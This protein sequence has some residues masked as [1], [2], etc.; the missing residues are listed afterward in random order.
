MKEIQ[1]KI[2]YL[3]YIHKKAL[4]ISLKNHL[5]IF[6]IME[7]NQSLICNHLFNRIAH[8]KHKSTCHNLS[9]NNIFI[10]TILYIFINILF[11][12]YVVYCYINEYIYYYKVIC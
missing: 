3:V 6:R 9:F 11:N 7:K 5:L 12:F 4:N 10:I 1:K 8:S 2:L